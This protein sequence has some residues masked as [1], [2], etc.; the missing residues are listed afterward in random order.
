M[1]CKRLII[2]FLSLLAT[3]AVLAGPKPKDALSHIKF[4]KCRIVSIVPT[5]LRS[6]RA[7]VELETRN[8]TSAF[9]LQDVKLAIFRKG[10][11][12][13]EGVCEEVSVPKGASKVHVTGVFELYDE[14]SL[15]SA[16]SVLR[17]PDLSEFTGN[18]DLTVV[19][20]KGKKYA[21]SEK[22][23]S[24]GSLGVRTAE[25]KADVK[26]ASSDG[27]VPSGKEQV[28]VPDKRTEATAKP[29][30]P[31]AAPKQKKARKRPWWQFWKK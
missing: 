17:N 29:A 13:A 22:D 24:L 31:P 23:L 18:V 25:R 19:S 7:G 28:S 12:F 8:D 16:V 2:T 11:P 21:Y 3:L 14:V 15:W 4:G 26:V 5:G 1:R 10:E 27:K 6:V 9:T 30:D 20:A